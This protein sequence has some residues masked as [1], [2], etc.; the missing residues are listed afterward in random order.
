MKTFK[1]TI[2][3]TGLLMTSPLAFANSWVGTADYS[4]AV[5][6]DGFEDTVAQFDTYDFGL[7]VALVKFSP[8]SATTGTMQ[9]WY[10]SAVVSHSFDFG[11]V[12]APNLNSTGSGS[13]YE[14]TA[15]ATFSGSYVNNGSTQTFTIDTGN[16][17]LYFDT[18]PDFNFTTDSGFSN[19]SAILY[20]S[21][22]SG[23]GSVKITGNNS[24][25]GYQD[26]SLSFTGGLNGYDHNVYSPDT[27]AGGDAIFTIK[28]KGVSILTSINS[29]QGESKVGGALF[30]SDG[31]LQLTAVPVPAAVWM[32]GTG[33]LALMAGGKRKLA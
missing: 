13:G 14:L 26:M 16:V 15:I 29:V 19:G 5:G 3:V 33:L 8:T 6:S 24:G 22:A 18:N 27:I 10:Q 1:H 2:L 17:G 30:A 23:E 11:T 25:S 21:I 12:A 28:T 32:F 4:Q 31:N 9:G 7:G 20:G